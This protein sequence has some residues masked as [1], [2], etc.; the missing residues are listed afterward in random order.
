MTYLRRT[1]TALA[2]VLW[3][4]GALRAQDAGAPAA[5]GSTAPR[6]FLD[7][8]GWYC[9]L[10]FYRTEITW[11]NWVRDRKGAQVHLLVTTQTTGGGG[12]EYTLQFIGLED[13]ASRQEQLRYVAPTTATEDEERRGLGQVMK[14]GLV[15]YA[16]RSAIAPRLQ[17]TFD[18]PKEQLPSPQKPKDPWN[19]WVYRIGANG[20]FSGES[21]SNSS[22]LFGS[23][24]ATR[25]TEL[26]RLRFEIEGTRSTS[27]FEFDDGTTY[28]SNLKSGGANALVVRSVSDHW[29]A[30]FNGSGRTSDREN[31]E[32]SLRGAPGIEYNV[33]PYKES[34]RRQL[35]LLYELGLNSYRYKDTTVYG[36]IAEVRADQSLTVS[37]VTKQPWG[38]TNLSLQAASY[39]DDW[40]K[41]HVTLFGGLNLR[42]I[43]GLQLNLFGSYGRVRDQLYLPKQG[44]SDEEVLLRLRQLQT[45][46]RY[47]VSAGLSYTFGSLFN[48]IVNPRF[49]G[50][51]GT[52]FFF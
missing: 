47:F 31:M 17:V 32:L 14:L 15:G 36:R 46:Y 42:V 12:R 34:T 2:A 10:D 6:V 40:S 26:W 48:N 52:T 16:A 29:S 18:T 1:A 27:H 11:V 49:G 28:D 50:S 35:T 3:L 8:Q 7:C 51:E 24:R 13:Y 23:I 20:Y 19:Y 43:K 25:T 37:L 9:D 45:S 41:N 39:L 33:Y 30:G 38:S 22:D 44:A 5:S 21:R 4:A